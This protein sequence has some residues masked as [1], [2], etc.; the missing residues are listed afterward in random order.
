MKLGSVE[1]IVEA[2][3]GVG[4]RFIVAGGLAVNVHG[5]ARFTRDLDLVIELL[6][7]NVHAAYQ[8][9]DGLGFRP[10]VP[11]SAADL[12]NLEL[13]ERMI[14]EKGMQVLQFYSDQHRETPVDIF[15]QPPFDFDEEYDRALVRTL[16][17]TGGVRFVAL[18]TLIRMK[19]AAGRPQDLADIS[20]LRILAEPGDDEAT[21]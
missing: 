19:E 15:V 11:V 8:A 14:R 6:P 5:F 1:A 12:S 9:L 21:S 2:L 17:G 18:E 3:E 10:V 16:P 13:R 4:V 20:Q 7:E